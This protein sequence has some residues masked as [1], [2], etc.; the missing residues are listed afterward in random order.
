MVMVFPAAARM[1]RL[2]MRF[3]LAPRELFAVHEQDRLRS[4]VREGQLGDMGAAAQLG[5]RHP[6]AGERL[7]S[8]NQCERWW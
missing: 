5:N 3:C 1:V 2:R 6:S 8:K 7:V 4:T